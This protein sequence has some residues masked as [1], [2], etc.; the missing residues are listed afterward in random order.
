MKIQNAKF[1]AAA[2][3]I[4]IKTHVVFSFFLINK[5]TKGNIYSSQDCFRSVTINRALKRVINLIKHIV[6]VS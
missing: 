4:T 5:S 3:R 2:T 6:R 1:I